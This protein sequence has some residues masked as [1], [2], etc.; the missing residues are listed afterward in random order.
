M[1]TAIPIED[2]KNQREAWSNEGAE[3]E[4]EHHDYDWN[5]DHLALAQIPS[6]GGAA[7]LVDQ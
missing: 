2:R 4:D 7:L 5:P 6:G 3:H 1:P